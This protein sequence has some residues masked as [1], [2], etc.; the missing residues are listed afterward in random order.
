[1]ALYA[2]DGTWNKDEVDDV[3]DTNVVRFREVYAGAD[4]EY[5]TGVGTRFG[6][7]GRALGG[8]LGVGGRSRIHEMYDTLRENWKRGDQEIDIIG[9]S[10]GAA[11]AVHFANKIG[12]EG[13]E[14]ADGETVIPEIRFLGVWDVVGSFGL[15]FDTFINFHEIN[16]GWN[17]DEVAGCVK[18]CYHAM[19]LDERR[20]TFGV[21]RLD[22]DHR[23]ENVEEIWFRGAHSDIGGGNRNVRRSNIA[24]QWMLEKARACGV[25][26]NEMRAS[27]PKYSEVDRWALVSENRDPVI[28]PRREVLAGDAFHPWAKAVTLDADRPSRTCTVLAELRYNWSGVRLEAGKTYTVEVLPGD[29]TWQDGGIE[30]G[31]DGWETEQLPWLKEKLVGLFEDNRRVPEA[32]WFELIGAEGDEDDDKSKLFRVGKRVEHTAK[33]DADLYLFANDLKSKYDNNE[34][35]LKVTITLRS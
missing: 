31:A 26:I 7:I 32:N 3:E 14:G 2:F 28:D 1:M 33:S 5:L 27:E 23:L 20:E 11:L 21:T 13:V 9:F 19:S 15:S 12:K 17:I 30:C 10:R 29:Q 25:P 4:F 18:N 22:E 35:F 8:I 34:G 16:L 24:L 6:A